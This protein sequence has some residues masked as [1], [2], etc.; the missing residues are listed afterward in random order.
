MTVEPRR[1]SII[2]AERGAAWK[3]WADRLSQGGAEKVLAIQ[4]E[5]ETP[6]EFASRVRGRVARLN[7]LGLGVERGVIVGGR[8]RGQA[9]VSSRA[10]VIKTLVAAIAA[11]GRGE[12][13][14]D[15]HEEDRI[16]MQA[17]ADSVEELVRGTGVRVTAEVSSAGMARSA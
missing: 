11:E 10:N 9:V 16:T 17:L 13:A 12:V 14:L 1:I 2:V 7:A 5:G 6:N 4:R 3:T 8:G 15:G